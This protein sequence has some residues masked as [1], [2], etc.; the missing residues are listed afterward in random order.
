M[1]RKSKVFFGLSLAGLIIA[2]WVTINYETSAGL[3]YLA[4]AA[5]SIF[6]LVNFDKIRRQ[7]R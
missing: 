7:L 5:T 4:L 3:I 1:K 6:V 2:G